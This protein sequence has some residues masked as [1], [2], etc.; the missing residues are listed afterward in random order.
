[1]QACNLLLS[2]PKVR[3]HSSEIY[4]ANSKQAGPVATAWLRY[5]VT[6]IIRSDPLKYA[7]CTYEISI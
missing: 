4:I 1:M 7:T 3:G 6:G 5:I 2:N